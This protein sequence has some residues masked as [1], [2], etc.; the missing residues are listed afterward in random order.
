MTMKLIA[1]TALVTMFST[2]AWAQVT[3]SAS[4]TDN[5][6]IPD[7]VPG[8]LSIVSE[9]INLNNTGIQSIT[10]VS[11][12]LNVA[13]GDNGVPWNGDYY[14]YLTDPSGSIAIL[15]NRV[16]VTDA[17]N[18]NDFGY[19]DAG[20]DITL[21]DS[22][23]DIHDYNNYSPSFNGD[24]QLTGTWGPDGR[25]SSPFSVQASDPRTALL[26]VFD[27]SGANGAW[28]L[29][30]ADASSGD[31][32]VLDG[33]SLEV[34]GTGATQTVP[35]GGGAWAL[36]LLSGLGLLLFARRSARPLTVAQGKAR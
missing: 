21:S 32:G 23:P 33:W 36:P 1:A 24:G 10:S 30:I 16:G 12:T 29:A 35:D 9:N 25:N 27:G 18:P 22:G 20:F 5:D 2:S 13:A 34:S 17:S 7:Y 19:S 26:D 8:N 28:T 6:L 14:A 11:V 15:L 3:V 4:Q 31:F